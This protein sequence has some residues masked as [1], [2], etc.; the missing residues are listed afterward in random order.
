MWLADAMHAFGPPAEIAIILAGHARAAVKRRI[1]ALE[2]LVM[3]L[4]LIEAGRLAPAV[5]PTRAQP[6]GSCRSPSRAC[7]SPPAPASP[8][9]PL[10]LAN[11]AAWRVRFILRIPA[12]QRPPWTPPA[13][14]GPRIR[15]LGRPLLVRDIWR[16]QE[17]CQRMARLARA[18]VARY[19]VDEARNRAKSQALAR[20]FE[21]LKRAIANPA[22]HARRLLAKLNAQENTHDAAMRVAMALPPPKQLNPIVFQNAEFHACCAVPAVLAPVRVDSS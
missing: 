12:P 2:T 8:P 13:N 6:S 9:P 19:L 21:A 22:P 16:E 20:R 5:T 4:L 1:K 7:V 17:R 11:P 14:S 18:R 15:D 3:K 10:D